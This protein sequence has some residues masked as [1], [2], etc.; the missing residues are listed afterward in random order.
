MVLWMVVTMDGGG[1]FGGGSCAQ[2]SWMVKATVDG[3]SG[4]YMFELIVV[5]GGG[6]GG[7]WR[8]WW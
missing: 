4:Q 2:R 5:V 8:L 7:A 1:N 6:G 3:D